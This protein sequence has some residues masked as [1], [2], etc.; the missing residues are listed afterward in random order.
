MSFVIYLFIC[1]SVGV[2][3]EVNSRSSR[4]TSQTGESLLE[5]VE[6]ESA[7]QML[8]EKVGKTDVSVPYKSET[9][10][11]A[12]MDALVV[13]EKAIVKLQAGFRGYCN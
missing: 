7:Q 4:L 5:Q 10:S 1:R 13:N 6:D 2:P 12:T 8:R 3:G 11:M 9:Q